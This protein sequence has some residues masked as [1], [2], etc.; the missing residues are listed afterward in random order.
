MTIP[1]LSA[2][3]ASRWC[4]KHFGRSVA[5]APPPHEARRCGRLAGTPAPRLDCMEIANHG[6]TSMCEN[7]SSLRD[8]N[9]LSHSTQR[10][11][12]GCTLGYTESPLRGWFLSG[13]YHHRSADLVL[14]L[15][16]TPVAKSESLLRS[17]G[18][19]DPASLACRFSRATS[20]LQR[21][22]VVIPNTD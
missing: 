6:P 7:L 13:L 10:S 11:A 14:T 21:C 4:R 9:L 22:R 1:D 8:S 20:E 5:A 12:S 17:A 19:A 3:R 16:L 15:A 2:R 18:N